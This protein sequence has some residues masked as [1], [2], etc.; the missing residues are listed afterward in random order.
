V[1]KVWLTIAGLVLIEV[2]IGL[3]S[4]PAAFIF[5]GAALALLPIIDNYLERYRKKPPAPPGNGAPHE[6]RSGLPTRRV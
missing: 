1:R 3:L 5:A 6:S 4:V 2:G